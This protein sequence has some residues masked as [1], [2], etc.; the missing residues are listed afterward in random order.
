MTMLY[1]NSFEHDDTGFNAGT[2]SATKN[3]VE[4]KLQGLRTIKIFR[5]FTCGKSTLN[6]EEAIQQKK[7]ILFNLSKG[8]YGDEASSACGRFVLACLL[9]I[10]FGRES[11]E[12]EDRVPVHVFI[13]ECQNFLVSSVEEIL[14]EARKYGLHLTLAQQKA[15]DKMLKDMKSAVFTNTR[16]KVGGFIPDDKAMPEML[17]VRLE[18]LQALKV[19]EF[20]VRSGAKPSIQILGDT[21][22]LDWNNGMTDEQWREVVKHQMR[23]YRDVSKD[24]SPVMP[25]SDPKRNDGLDREEW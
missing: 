9:K 4:T 25:S 18:D 24:T 20:F 6:L 14:R 12:K 10:A 22:V 21:D 11:L 15:G 1:G 23:Y 13:D 17:G 19:G 7:V 5:E 2:V 16:I 8:A 3:S